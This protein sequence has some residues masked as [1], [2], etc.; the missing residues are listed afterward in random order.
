MS[1]FQKSELEIAAMCGVS[2]E[3]YKMALQREQKSAAIDSLMTPDEKKIC[4]STG[5][6]YLDYLKEAGKLDMETML[7]SDEIDICRVLNIAPLDF[8]FAKKFKC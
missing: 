6:E 1:D 4:D 2:S 7:T 3:E 8:Y 5:V